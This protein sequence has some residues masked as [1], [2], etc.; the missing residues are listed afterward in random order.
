MLWR[1][2]PRT[3]FREFLRASSRQFDEPAEIFMYLWAGILRKRRWEKS[4]E[5]VKDDEPPPRKRRF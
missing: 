4:V 2:I 5:S 1:R 3:A